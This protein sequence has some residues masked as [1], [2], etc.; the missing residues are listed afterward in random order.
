MV[1]TINVDKK[2]LRMINVLITYAV[3]STYGLITED[4]K[5]NI[6]K[7]VGAVIKVLSNFF[8]P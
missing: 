2:P 3:F 1:L 7:L 6:I 5:V 8:Y 4:D